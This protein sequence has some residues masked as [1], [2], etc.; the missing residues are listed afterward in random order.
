MRRYHSLPL[1]VKIIILMTCFSVSDS[2]FAAEKKQ[3]SFQKQSFDKATYDQMMVD[4]KPV[5]ID[6]YA[7][8]C[9]TCERQQWILQDYF[10]SNPESKLTVMVVDFDDDKKWV[11]Y[12]KA[13]RQS[14]LLLFNKGERVWFSVA[15]TRKRVIFDALDAIK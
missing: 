7:S 10:E 13:P 1:V 3:P 8:W 5:L 14:T 12:F 4:G 15:E 9:P 2:L 6:V 11:S